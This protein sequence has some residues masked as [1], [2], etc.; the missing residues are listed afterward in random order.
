MIL[1]REEPNAYAVTRRGAN[2][3]QQGTDRMGGSRGLRS[4][5]SE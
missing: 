3:L 5:G 1:D 2:V 4:T